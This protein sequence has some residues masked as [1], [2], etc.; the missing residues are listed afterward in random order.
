MT[1]CWRRA[2][3]A[4]GVFAAVAA[5]QTPAS[6]ATMSHAARPVVSALS[7]HSSRLVGGGR[8]TISGRNFERGLS[9]T[10]GGVRV[11]DIRRISATRLRVAV[12]AHRAGVTSVRVRDVGG[13]S[14]RTRRSRL[15]YRAPPEIIAVGPKAVAADDPKTIT[16]SGRNFRGISDVRFTSVEGYEEARTV[17]VL[18]S[19]LLKV[20]APNHGAGTVTVQVRGRFGTSPSIRAARLTYVAAPTV[21]TTY[22]PDASTTASYRAVLSTGDDAPGTWTIAD[23]TLPSGLRLSNGVIVGHP[24]TAGV[25]PLTMRYTDRVGQ[26]ADR[27]FTLFVTDG[28]WSAS[29]ADALPPD[30]L[31]GSGDLYGVDCPSSTMCAAV[32]TYQAADHTTRGLL[33]TWVDGTWS[34]TPMV[35]DGT[36]AYPNSTMQARPISCGAPGSCVAIGEASNESVV[37]VA[38]FA[39]NRWTQQPAPLLPGDDINRLRAVSC[40]DA[41]TCVAVGDHGYGAFIETLVGGAWHVSAP[42]AS[43]GADAWLLDVDCAQPTTCVA[44]GSYP[45]TSL[46]RTEPLVLTLADGTWQQDQVPAP[47]NV[48]AQY[49]DDTELRAVSCPTTTTCTAVGGYNAQGLVETQTRDGWSASGPPV[50]RLADLTTVSCSTDTCLIA[51]SRRSAHNGPVAATLHGST[52]SPISLPSHTW[53][54]RSASCTD[55][56]LCAFTG[57]AYDSSDG[58]TYGLLGTLT[59]TSRTVERVAVPNDAVTHNPTVTVSA[60]F[61]VSCP[62]PTNCVAVGAYQTSQ[63]TIAT[64]TDNYTP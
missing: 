11:R 34:T 39:N 61:G 56:G 51:G 1:M 33:A 26:R 44:V 41:Q 58:T 20:T 53:E 57:S 37:V 21:T 64:L 8:L 38:S 60:P 59:S 13:R 49:P 46:Q 35:V 32:G 28:H 29:S 9:V 43:A 2:A 12:P 42:P 45:D 30:A 14:A 31:P 3:C 50:G 24:T 27:S 18:S 25:T 7:R 52:W 55:G 47:S 10:V 36:P 23:G 62:A 19:H 15:V 6:S 48:I 5:T 4:F 16:I 63:T 17:H 54:I 22:L 40:A